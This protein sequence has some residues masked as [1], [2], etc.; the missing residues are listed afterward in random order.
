MY[1][2]TESKR[3]T[4]VFFLSIEFPNDYPFSPPKLSFRTRIY[5]C[6]IN[7]KGD[8]CLESLKSNWSP[9]LTV[10]NLLSAILGLLEDPNPHNPLVGSIAVQYITDRT[11]HDE[12]ARDW[13]E[14]FAT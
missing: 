13:T 1:K 5:H 2:Q 8:V 10:S 11:K 4:G 7:S 6:N 3:L 9:A 12:T 14:R